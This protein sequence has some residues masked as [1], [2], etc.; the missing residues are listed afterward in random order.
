V[1]FESLAELEKLNELK[2]NQLSGV[3]STI[4][5]AFI[6]AISELLLKTVSGAGAIRTIVV[7]AQELVKS[8]GALVSVRNGLLHDLLLHFS[9][10]S[11][12][13]IL[14]ERLSNHSHALGS[15]QMRVVE[16]C[17][18]RVHVG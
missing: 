3:S 8:G 14:K 5:E 13:L 17:L 1:G 2:I 7:V 12:K 15:N 4:S 6:S 11:D 16:R 18:I 10:D 9:G